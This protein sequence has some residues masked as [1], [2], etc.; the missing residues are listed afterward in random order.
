MTD[1]EQQLLERLAAVGKAS[2]L[3]LGELQ[4]AKSLEKDGLLF[5]VGDTA[6]AIITPKRQTRPRRQRTAETA[7]QEAAR[8]SRIGRLDSCREKNKAPSVRVQP[9][10]LLFRLNAGGSSGDDQQSSDL[11]EAGMCSAYECGSQGRRP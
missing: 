4:V 6:Y 7:Q 8:F 10:A 3:A 1:S 5:M 11:V 2:C 9:E